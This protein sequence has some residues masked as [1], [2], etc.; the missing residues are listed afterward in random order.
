MHRTSESPIE[1]ERSAPFEVVDHTTP[2][3]AR[4]QLERK[5]ARSWVMTQ[6]QQ[7]FLPN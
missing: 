1:G 4:E 7:G 6:R 5:W 2:E 3:F